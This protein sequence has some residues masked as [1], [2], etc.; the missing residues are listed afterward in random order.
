[1]IR[2]RASTVLVV[3][4]MLLVSTTV[5]YAASAEAGFR[6]SGMASVDDSGQSRR[7][8][9]RLVLTRPLSVADVVAKL[10][11]LD[12]DRVELIR[13]DMVNGMVYTS[14]VVTDGNDLSPDL[15]AN[16]MASMFDDMAKELA[17][18]AAGSVPDKA[19]TLAVADAMESAAKSFAAT[20][21]RIEAIVVT[22][23]AGTLHLLADWEL[24][25]S[26]TVALPARTGASQPPTNR[27]AE[28]GVQTLD[29]GSGGNCDN[30][31]WPYAGRISTQYSSSV[32]NRYVW[33]RFKWS[34]WRIDN[35]YD[36]DGFN[37]SYEHEA[38][39]NNYDGLHFLSSNVKSWSSSLPDAYLDTGFLDGDG[40]LG[41]TIGTGAAYQLDADVNYTTYIRTAPGNAMSDTGKV[42]GQRGLNLCPIGLTGGWCVF[43]RGTEKL[44]PAW[45][46][47]AP[48]RTDWTHY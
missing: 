27:A 6:P 26:S 12:I 33:Q 2:R 7:D 20:D 40:E 16:E 38:W 4:V 25:G 43:A 1:M 3:V 19:E 22:A 37:T 39:Y 13:R 28:S 8:T 47:S 17:Q 23:S 31:W 24:V 9:V 48:G 10:R 41:L 35:L 32:P 29:A 5:A 21:A 30:A 45:S 36:C 18:S 15:Y 34:Q 44:L 14:G 46:H 11:G 42:N